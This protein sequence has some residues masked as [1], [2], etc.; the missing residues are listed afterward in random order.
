MRPANAS[1]SISKADGDLGLVLERS[2]LPVPG[3]SIFHG[4]LKMEAADGDGEEMVVAGQVMVLPTLPEIGINLKGEGM[5][6]I[7]VGVANTEDWPVQVG[8]H[9]CKSC[10]HVMSSFLLFEI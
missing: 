6:L 4:A 9:Y 7:E 10:A 5:H 3:V 2:I 8:S 1:N